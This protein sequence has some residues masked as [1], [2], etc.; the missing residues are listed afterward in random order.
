M[1][2]EM[3]LTPRAAESVNFSSYSAA[4]LVAPVVGGAASVVYVT[5][6][7]GRYYSVSQKSGRYFMAA[8]LLARRGVYSGLAVHGTSYAMYQVS[9]PLTEKLSYLSNGERREAFVPGVMTGS[10][11]TSDD[12]SQVTAL[13]EDGSFGV[14]GAADITATL[15]HDL[16]RLLNDGAANHEAAVQSVTT[17]LQKYGY[18]PEE[19]LVLAEQQ[20]AQQRAASA[21]ATAAE[22]PAV[23]PLEPTVTEGT[24]PSLFPAGSNEPKP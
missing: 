20:A 16:S 3:K 5:E 10:L 12:E 14:V 13:Q 2:Y 22:S 8:N 17:L 23:E 24:E 18:R 7:P 4:Y 9:G 6:D 15:R 21:A 19:E 11:L 1:V